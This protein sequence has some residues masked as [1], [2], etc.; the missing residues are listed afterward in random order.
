MSSKIERATDRVIER[1]CVR[2]RRNVWEREMGRWEI[3]RKA[4]RHLKARRL[5]ESESE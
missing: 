4:E 2:E 5:V 3:E 1:E